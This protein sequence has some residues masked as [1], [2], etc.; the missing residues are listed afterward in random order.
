MTYT[1]AVFRTLLDMPEHVYM[2]LTPIPDFNS[3]GTNLVH[4]ILKIP[5]LMTPIYQL[6]NIQMK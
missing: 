5:H 6:Y 3:V 2:Y 1:Y 4:F